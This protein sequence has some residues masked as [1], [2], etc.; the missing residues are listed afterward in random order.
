MKKDTMI[1]SKEETTEKFKNFTSRDIREAIKYINSCKYCKG[2]KKYQGKICPAC[3]GIDWE[4]SG[5]PIEYL[6]KNEIEI[7]YNHLR[8]TKIK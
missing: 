8:K 3:D 1:L 4:P 5:L 6:K 7:L 2:T